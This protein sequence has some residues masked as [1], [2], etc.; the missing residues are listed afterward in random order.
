[1]LH[2]LS[3]WWTDERDMKLEDKGAP[4]WAEL[5]GDVSCGIPREGSE[6]TL[7]CVRDVVI[8]VR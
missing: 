3:A 2:P 5:V 8:A 7:P 1:M 6:S 4:L